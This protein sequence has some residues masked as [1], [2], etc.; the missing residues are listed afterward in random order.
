MKWIKVVLLLFSIV[1]LCA[2]AEQPLLF[3][4]TNLPGEY[5]IAVQDQAKGLYSQKLPLIP[6]FAKVENVADERIYYT[7]YYFPFGTV[8]MSYHPTDGYNIEKPLLRM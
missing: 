1:L 6:A 3:C 7:I 8:G 5:K 4:K 2:F